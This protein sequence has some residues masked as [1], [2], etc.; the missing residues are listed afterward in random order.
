[1]L[2]EHGSMIA[3]LTTR[4]CE[5]EEHVAGLHGRHRNEIKV[6]QKTAYIAM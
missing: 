2:G 5:G 4:G 6:A 3:A 1:M